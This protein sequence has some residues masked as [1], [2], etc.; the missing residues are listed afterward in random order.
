VVLMFFDFNVLLVSCRDAAMNKGLPMR[1]INK[2]LMVLFFML[3]LA[4][5]TPTTTQAS[6][7]LGINLSGP[8]D[9]NTELPFVDVF[10]LSRSWISQ[11][12]GQ[13]WGKG[14]KLEL[15]EYGW[16][17]RL[18]AGCHADTLLCTIDGGHYPSGQY[19][20][21]YDG[22]GTIN[23]RGAATVA[24]NQPGRILVNVD[25]SKGGFFLSIAQTNP[26]HYIRNIRVIMPGFED[27]YQDNFWHPDFLERWKG[28]ACLRFMDFMHTN[29]SQIKTWDD[30]SEIRDATWTGQGGIPLEMLC[31]L[32]NRTG[33]A[34]WFC[35][36]H[37][38]NDD[39]V[40]RFA[41]LVK[42][43]L[44]PDLKIYIEY[45]NEVWNTQFQQHQ[46]AGEQGQKLGLATRPWE[47]AWKYTGRR[48][49]EIFTIWEEVFGSND[50]LIR[51]LASHA[52]NPFVT[53]Q[54]IEQDEVY[55]QADVLAIAP[56]I[57]M[58]TK[59]MDGD[60]LA[61]M[62]VQGV[63]DK[64]ENESLPRAIEYIRKHQ[65]LADKHNL[66]LVCYEAGQHMVGI[67]GG[68]NNKKLNEVF[69]AANAHPRMAEIYRKYFA[70]WEEAN[71]D[72][73]AMFISVEK[74]SKWGSWGLMQ[75]ADQSPMSQTKMQAVLKQ[76]RT[77]GQDV[78]IK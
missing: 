69:M 39:Y 21:L 24:Q 5:L 26:D 25:S 62:G 4:S 7:R 56:Y 31:D 68:E 29:H 40:R 55:K 48:S 6:P 8:R 11:K 43:Q 18:E 13:P 28:F 49:K 23:F 78:S 73:M 27:S 61:A 58:N 63:L 12:P 35:I 57:S 30:R 37:M 22:K 65:A 38:A 10:H 52:A 14:P 15:D 32:A 33:I 51:V 53:R 60:A 71:G 20:V 67:Q 77:W 64:L 16:V 42:E 36:P 45:S 41:M 46:Y 19:V 74:W 47:A 76:A 34:P 1:T 9:W 66:K 3:S 70:A 75:Y 54:I 2:W 59:A 44:N 17:K 72:M 50:R